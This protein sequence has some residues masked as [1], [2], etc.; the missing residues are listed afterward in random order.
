M[1]PKILSFDIESAGVNALKADLGFVILFGYKWAHEEEAHVITIDRQSLRRFDDKALL[2]QASAIM[3]QA[4]LVVGHFASLFDRRF[5]QGR[6]LINGLPPIPPTKI[7]DTCLI[8]RSLATF[9]SNRLKHLAKILRLSHQKLDNNWP[10]AWFK[11]MQG[12]VRHLNALAKYCKGDVEAVEELYFK[13]R[14]FDQ[15]H[16]RLYP[17]EKGT[18]RCAACGGKVAWRGTVPLGENVYRRYQC[19]TCWRWGRERKALQWA[20][21]TR[22]QSLTVRRVPR[23]RSGGRPESRQPRSAR[24]APGRLRSERQ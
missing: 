12:S 20:N 4:D 14:P 24:R 19:L 23:L 17:S 15:P 1:Y 21:E 18:T 8:A 16:P 3:A 10:T 7:R 11:V 22:P 13:L 2:R 6:L 9:S 5:I